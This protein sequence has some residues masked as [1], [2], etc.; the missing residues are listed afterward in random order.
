MKNSGLLR[1]AWRVAHSS[2]IDESSD[3]EWFSRTRD[4]LVSVSTG[5]SK[6]APKIYT[7]CSGSRVLKVSWLFGAQG[8]L[9]R[10]EEAP[11][12]LRFF[13]FGTAKSS[14][15]THWR[16]KAVTDE[17]LLICILLYDRFNVL[18]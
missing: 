2:K 10:V 13:N 15:Q 7:R 18:D 6:S 16:T 9:G 12:V 4:W 17:F 3:L 5:N 1:K 11:G 8:L 14:V